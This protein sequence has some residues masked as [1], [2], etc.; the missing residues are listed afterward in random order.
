MSAGVSV[1]DAASMR[2]SLAAMYRKLEDLHLSL[3]ARDFWSQ[4]AQRQQKQV[5]TDPLLAVRHA[6]IS[7]KYQDPR[8]D[9]PKHARVLGLETRFR[10]AGGAGCRI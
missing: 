7:P 1:G 4:R 2:E 10:C 6:A 8:R 5:L 9:H 3:H